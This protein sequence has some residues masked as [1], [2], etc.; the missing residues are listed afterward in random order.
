M[1][2][3][4]YAQLSADLSTVLI[5]PISIDSVLVASWQTA[6]N[7]KGTLYRVINMIAQPTFD[8]NTQAIIQNGWTITANDVEPVWQI[9][10][11]TAAQQQVVSNATQW[12]NTVA[13]NLVAACTNAINNWATLT[14]AQKDT[15]LLDLVKFVRAELQYQYAINN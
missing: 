14:A 13:I 10:T 3:Q 4:N 12:N 8:P 2:I 9:I 1:S 11:L 7:P 6:G 15:V 5:A